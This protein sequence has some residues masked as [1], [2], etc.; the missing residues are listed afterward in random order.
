MYDKHIKNIKEKPIKLVSAFKDLMTLKLDR[1]DYINQLSNIL[2]KTIK[3]RHIRDSIDEKEIELQIDY[4]DDVVENKEEKEDKED[5]DSAIICQKIQKDFFKNYDVPLAKMV[6][7]KKHYLETGK[8][9]VP[10]E[11]T[12]KGTNDFISSDARE[13]YFMYLRA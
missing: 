6:Y 13:K 4:A 10:H 12:I 2:P 9:I 3:E 8:Y 11:I 1:K 7:Y 5:N